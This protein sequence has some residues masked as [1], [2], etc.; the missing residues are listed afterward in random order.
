M[1]SKRLFCGAVSVEIYCTFEATTSS[2]HCLFF[3]PPLPHF[4]KEGADR[5]IAV[6]TQNEILL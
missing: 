5:I 6:L 2:L 1:F 3:M 4:T